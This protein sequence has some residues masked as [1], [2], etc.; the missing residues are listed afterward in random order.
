MLASWSGLKRPRQ[1]HR[2]NVLGSD[3]GQRAV[4]SAGIIAVV[5][6]PGVGRRVCNSGGIKPLGQKP[7]RKKQKQTDGAQRSFS[8][9]EISYFLSQRLQ[10]GH[11]VMDVVVGVFFE[12]LD[13]S[14][15][16]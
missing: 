1:P 14:V 15:R 6:R 8:L 5:A 10:V 12:L 3:L 2:C 16:G 4:S 11:Q 7:A 13:M 9:N